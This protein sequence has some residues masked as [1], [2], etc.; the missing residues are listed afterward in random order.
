MQSH[1][2]TYFNSRLCTRG[3]SKHVV[4]ESGFSWFQFTPLHERQYSFITS[5][6][7]FAYFNSRL[8]M[9]G[10]N[11]L[12]FDRV[13]VVISILASA[14]EATY[15]FWHLSSDFRISIHASTWEAASIGNRQFNHTVISILAS[16]WEATF[17]NWNTS[18]KF[19]I[20]IH[21]SAWEAT[22]FVLQYGF[23]TFYFN[24]RLCMRGN[25]GAIAS[26]WDT[27]FQFSPLH[28]RQRRAFL[29]RYQYLQI[30]IHAST[31]E[32]TVVNAGI[33]D[34]QGISIHASTWEATPDGDG[35]EE[36]EPISIH[37]STWEAT[38]MPSLWTVC[39]RY[40]NSRLYM[41]GNMLIRCS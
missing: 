21:A 15:C 29:Y 36:A 4:G 25:P 27:L 32:A 20:S 33:V 6:S 37:A 1:P 34:D 7:L 10:N 23:D 38:W 19:Y 14:W 13:F 11:S 30:S 31:W 12:N 9:R 28:E 2:Y 35:L 17:R 26:G 41:R 5:E 40:F 16:A 39:A 8:C 22:P 18:I 3:N 24:S